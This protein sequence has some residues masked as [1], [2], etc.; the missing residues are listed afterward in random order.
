MAT[1]I[2]IDGDFFL[3]RYRQLRGRLSRERVA[4]DLHSMCLAHLDQRDGRRDLY[5]ILFYDC[6]PLSKKAHN[7]LTGRAIDF[8]KTPTAEW[9]REFH[10]RLRCLQKVALRLGYL[11]EK[12]GHWTIRDTPMG[13]VLSGKLGLVAGDSDFVPAAKLARREGIDFI[14]DPLWATI[15]PDLHEHVD[16][17]HTV[18]PRPGGD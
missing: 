15:R 10:D 4:R 18:L 9:R 8:S 14:L 7:P 16:G 6:A 1:A 11:N 12:L 2:L 3:K 5:Q 17:L 13:N